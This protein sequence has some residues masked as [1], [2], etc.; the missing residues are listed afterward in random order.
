[1][2]KAWKQLAYSKRPKARTTTQLKSRA[3]E[4]WAVL[5]TPNNPVKHP[6]LKTL[7]NRS[8]PTEHRE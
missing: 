5:L 1:M 3:D 4:I 6:M 2:E 7:R 8:Q